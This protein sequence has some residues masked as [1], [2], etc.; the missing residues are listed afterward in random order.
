MKINSCDSSA[1]KCKRNSAQP[2]I[3][4]WSEKKIG[5][6]LIHSHETAIVVSAVVIFSLT[7]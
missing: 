3:F 7:V 5:I 1:H 2:S 6:I 4:C